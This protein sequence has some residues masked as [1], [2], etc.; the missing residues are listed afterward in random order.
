MLSQK[1]KKTTKMVKPI[2]LM[3]ERKLGETLKKDQRDQ[4]SEEGKSPS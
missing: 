1:K 3:P 4:F 2:I